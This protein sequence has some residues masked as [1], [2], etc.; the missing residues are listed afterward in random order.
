MKFRRHAT[1]GTHAVRFAGALSKVACRVADK[2]PPNQRAPSPPPSRGPLAGVRKGAHPKPA[3]SDDQ[4]AHGRWLLDQR[5]ATLPQICRW[6]G[7][8][9]LPGRGP[10]AGLFYSRVNR[11][12]VQPRQVPGFPVDLP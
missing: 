4:V 10:A 6:L 9:D 7:V 8:L 11:A 1:E 3:L 12:H 5:L 2:L